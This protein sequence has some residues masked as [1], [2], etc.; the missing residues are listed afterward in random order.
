MTNYPKCALG[1]DAFAMCRLLDSVDCAMLLSKLSMLQKAK[2]YLL[3]NV[4]LKD[5]VPRDGT[6][7]VYAVR[8]GRGRFYL[9][10]EQGWERE[11]FRWDNNAAN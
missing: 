2:L 9:S 4:P 1:N 11:L 5:A 10:Y 6:Y 8:E 7:L 3:G